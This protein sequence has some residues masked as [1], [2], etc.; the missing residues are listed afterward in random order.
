MLYLPALLL[1]H[2]FCFILLGARKETIIQ[3]QHAH[4]SPQWLY[5]FVKVV[6]FLETHG[7]KLRLWI[8]PKSLVSSELRGLGMLHQQQFKH[9][10]KKQEYL[11]MS[12]CCPN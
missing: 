9:K 10:L 3:E 7:W 12:K 11:P 2:I 8:S 1:K 5:S 4:S 6:N